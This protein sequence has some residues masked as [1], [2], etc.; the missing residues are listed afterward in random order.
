MKALTAALIAVAILYVVD[1][2][3]NDGRFTQAIEQAM[4]SLV[5]R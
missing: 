3:Y 4:T 5:P 1:S 2:Q